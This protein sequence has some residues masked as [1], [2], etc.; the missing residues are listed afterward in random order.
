[1]N[2]RIVEWKCDA[3]TG[4]VVAGGNG[5]GSRMDQL[6]RPTDVI[7]DKETD[8]VIIC[9]SGNRRVMRWPRR[10][11]TIGS[12][13]L[14]DIDCWGLAMDDQG[15][16]YVSDCKK[17]VVKRYR[18]GKTKEKV[19]AGSKRQGDRLDELNRP[20]Y[21]FVDQDHSVYVSDSCNRRVM[22][23]IKGAKEG[24]IVT[25]DRKKSND[26]AQRFCPEGVTV[27]AWG[28]VYVTDCG[29]HRVMCWPKGIGQG[30][31]IAGGY[32]EEEQAK[33]LSYPRGLSSDQYGNLY[34]ID[35]WNHRV[36]RFS[37]RETS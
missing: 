21:I 37:I 25:E 29:N 9:D 20:S 7:V 4:Q 30:V 24:T 28:A 3:T 33:Q 18:M 31:V 11:G 16:L 1:M 6:N 19:V 17:H 36:Q 15:S 12:T 10:S 35:Q 23:W 14:S 32:D 22:K 26:Q 27:D 5:Q 8:S 2:H 13:V 34:V